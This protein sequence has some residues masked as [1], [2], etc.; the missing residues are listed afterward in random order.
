ALAVIDEHV[1]AIIHERRTSGATHEDFLGLLLDAT[2]K[3]TGEKMPA[4]QV[5]DEAVT[6]LGAGHETSAS[7]MTW[8]M[9]H[10]GRNPEIAERIREE[11]A[12]VVGSNVFNVSHLKELRY[13][14]AV[15]QETLRLC[16]PVPL[17]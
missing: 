16:A 5:R 12:Q 15:I 10:I 7:A 11:L 14:Q 9:V 8:A 17:I 4:T 2:Y 1:L 13:L 6:M 3:D